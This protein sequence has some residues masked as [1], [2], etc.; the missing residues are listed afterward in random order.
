M[1]AFR[2]R[3]S[4]SM[5]E[6]ENIAFSVCQRLYLIDFVVVAGCVVRAICGVRVVVVVIVLGVTVVRGVV[7]GAAVVVIAVVGCRRCASV[8]AAVLPRRVG[9]V[10]TLLVGGSTKFVAVGLNTFLKS[11]S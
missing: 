7:L 9:A 8:V 3:F 5:D 10:T 2:K 6:R 1:N 4:H 11:S